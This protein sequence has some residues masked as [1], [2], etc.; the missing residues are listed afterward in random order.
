MSVSDDRDGNPLEVRNISEVGD[1]ISFSI[2][3]SENGADEVLIDFGFVDYADE[4]NPT[5]E[6]NFDLQN[7]SELLE[8]TVSFTNDGILSTDSIA[9]NFPLRFD[10]AATNFIGVE[11]N[12]VILHPSESLRCS[13]RICSLLS[14]FNVPWSLR[15]SFQEV[16]AALPIAYSTS[17]ISTS[18]GKEK[19]ALDRCYS[20]NLNIKCRAVMCTSVL[21]LDE[22]LIEFESCILHKLYSKEMHIWNRSES[23]LMFSLVAMDDHNE[24]ESTD[25][26]MV[27]QDGDT[28]FV[29][30]FGTPY[31]VPP[32]ASKSLRVAFTAK[33]ESISFIDLF[34]LLI[35]SK[36]FLRHC[37][38]KARGCTHS[39]FVI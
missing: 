16:V 13:L 5:L 1:S 35:Y 4:F 14:D 21:Q 17:I 29:L 11:D 15:T 34:S 31:S 3:E 10:I 37:R 32:F 33:V 23:I 22:P 36:C 39:K 19:G 24:S 30:E 6:L 12:R 18:K 2:R 20:S 7:S 28:D 9:G 25:E 27:F 26:T 8:V 38:S